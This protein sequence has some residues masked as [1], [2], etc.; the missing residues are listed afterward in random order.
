[1]DTL[2]IIIGFIILLAGSQIYWLVVAVACVIMGSYLENQSARFLDQFVSI[3]NSLKYGLLGIVLS[4]T[5]K[6][7]A[8]LAAGFVLG[9]YL[10]F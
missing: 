2:K 4:L 6:P 5:A 10:T 8:V 9:G 7:L 3:T 1:M